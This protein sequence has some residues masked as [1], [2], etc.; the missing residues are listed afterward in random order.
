MRG[1]TMERKWRGRL[2]F[3]GARAGSPFGKLRAGSRDSRRDGGAPP[4][5]VLL[6]ARWSDQGWEVANLLRGLRS[7]SGST[8]MSAQ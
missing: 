2:G 8:R 4:T 6:S 1:S 7:S 5:A 3:P